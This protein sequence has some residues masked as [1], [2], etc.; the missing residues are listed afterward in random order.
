[1]RMKTSTKYTSNYLFHWKGE[2][3]WK[4][5]HLKAF[6]SACSVGG[7]GL[8]P[9]LGRCPGEGNGN[10][11]QYSCLEN[12]MDEGAWQAT[13]HEIAKSRTQLSDFTCFFQLSS[14][15]ITIGK[16]TLLYFLKWNYIIIWFYCKVFCFCPY[17]DLL[18]FF[19]W[20]I[21]QGSCFV[22]YSFLTLISTK[23]QIFSD[24]LRIKSAFYSLH[25]NPVSKD[26]N[27]GRKYKPENPF[28]ICCYKQRTCH[29][30]SWCQVTNFNPSY[31]SGMK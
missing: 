15:I 27:T 19:A 4:K 22:N 8:I 31:L 17:G 9:G 12:P 7:Q 29:V 20:S 25:R 2:Q 10:P 28:G 18:T 16:K 1:M 14:S 30:L 21:P 6:Q 24:Y 26:N 11:L 13:V 23:A 3:E 5:R